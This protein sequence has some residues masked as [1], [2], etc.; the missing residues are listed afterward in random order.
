[1]RPSILS[2]ASAFALGF[3]L[4]LT[5]ILADRLGDLF[6]GGQ[7]LCMDK[8]SI[9]GETSLLLRECGADDTLV[10]RWSSPEKR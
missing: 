9:A 5:F 4:A 3:V 7:Q 8:R 1:M 6:E 10:R 2:A